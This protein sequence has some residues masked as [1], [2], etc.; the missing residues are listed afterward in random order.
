MTPREYGLVVEE[1]LNHSA[2]WRAFNSEQPQ[3][4]SRVGASIILGLF[5]YSVSGGLS[6][7]EM[8]VR[9]RFRQ[10]N[11]VGRPGCEYRIDGGRRHLGTRTEPDTIIK[12]D[13]TTR[14]CAGVVEIAPRSSERPLLSVVSRES[15]TGLSISRLVAGQRLNKIGMLR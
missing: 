6:G 11:A 9:R 14:L 2:E 5:D 8:H 15:L 1:F 10:R 7:G 3:T 13:G 4:R 12:R